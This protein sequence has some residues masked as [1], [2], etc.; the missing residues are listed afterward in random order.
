[1]KLKNFPGIKIALTIIIMGF[2][3]NCSN[4]SSKYDSC[5]QSC[6]QN[7]NLCYLTQINSTENV[8]KVACFLYQS[9]CENSCYSKK[10]SSRSTTKSSTRSRSSSSSRSGS[11]SSSSGGGSSGGGHSGGGHGGGGIIEF[12]GF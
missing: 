7:S 9:T 12:N 10:S 11:S 4:S 1:M 5:I 6:R 3:F 2:T 8:T